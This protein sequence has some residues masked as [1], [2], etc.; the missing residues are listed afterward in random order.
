MSQSP[1]LAPHDREGSI[2]WASFSGIFRSFR[3]ATHPYKLGLALLM[4]IAIFLAGTIM[5]GLWRGIGGRAA[6][7]GGLKLQGPMG[8]GLHE[9]LVNAERAAVNRLSNRIN[10]DLLNLT[11]SETRTQ[12]DVNREVESVRESF[13]ERYR[14]D[15]DGAIANI[16]ER[17]S[18]SFDRRITE[19]E[20]ELAAEESESGKLAIRDRINNL[21]SNK[22]R[23]I[24]TI[25]MTRYEIDALVF[26]RFMDTREGLAEGRIAL[27]EDTGPPTTRQFRRTLRS[28]HRGMVAGLTDEASEPMGLSQQ[29]ERA[30][31]NGAWQHSTAFSFLERYDSRPVAAIGAVKSNI[32]SNIAKTIADMRKEFEEENKEREDREAVERDR[33]AMEERIETLE[34]QRDDFIRQIDTV[35]REL[36]TGIFATWLEMGGVVVDRLMGIIPNPIMPS[37]IPP[38]TAITERIGLMITAL[39]DFFVTGPQWMLRAHTVYTIIFLPLVLAIF[40]FLGG[41]LA[42]MMALHATCNERVAA[43]DAILFSK[44]RFLSFFLAPAIPI[45]L[46]LG[47]GVLLMLLGLLANVPVLD[48]LVA[49]GFVLALLAGFL[50]ALLLIGLAGGGP[51]LYPAIATEGTDAF[52]AIARAFNYLFSRPWRWLGLVLLSVFYAGITIIFVT[53]LLTLTRDL[54]LYFVASG[55]FRGLEVDGTAINRFDALR[56]DD[57]TDLPATAMVASAALRVWLFV[58]QALVIAF[59]INILMATQTW[60]YL[61]LRQAADGTELDE[62]FHEEPATTNSGPTPDAS[63]PDKVEPTK[64]TD[65]QQPDKPEENPA[66]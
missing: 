43:M 6:I 60:V 22:I 51:M 52:D 9:V 18:R 12:A 63:T 30:D 24:E 54:A 35:G 4:V 28:I 8:V 32:R 21:R 20:Q 64:E 36:F 11:P 44:D 37:T 41:A 61:L 5:D 57:W 48:I 17:T 34:A 38:D 25:R 14:D 2:N 66:G 23:T 27:R 40:A 1:N 49:V 29:P 7:E 55:V 42:R 58:L 3:I 16:V 50:M 15:L 56:T 45:L 62:V 10:A 59:V 39:R 26:E 46:V 47:M 65:A 19:A 33:K 53:W 13:Q 31:G